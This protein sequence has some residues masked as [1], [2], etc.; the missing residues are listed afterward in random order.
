M[1]TFAQLPELVDRKV[2]KAHTQSCGNYRAKPGILSNLSIYHLQTGEGYYRV[3]LGF[4][5]PKKDNIPGPGHLPNT[6]GLDGQPCRDK[7]AESYRSFIKEDRRGHYLELKHT[8]ARI[9]DVLIIRSRS[10][11]II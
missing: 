10:E 11:K 5:P 1:T 8:K 3:I 7:A 4:S 6:L 9:N 2:L